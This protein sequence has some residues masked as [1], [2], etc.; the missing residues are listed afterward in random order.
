MFEVGGGRGPIVRNKANFPRHDHQSRRSGRLCETKPISAQTVMAEG[1]QGHPG[2]RRDASCETK[3]ICLERNGWQIFGR[4]RVMT[5]WNRRRLR[6]N[7]ANSRTDRSGQ[8]SAWPPVPLDG[9]IAQNEPNFGRSLKC[10]VPSVKPAK[11]GVESSKSSYFKLYTSNFRRNADSP[12][13]IVRNEANFRP[14]GRPFG[15]HGPPWARFP[16]LSGRVS[17]KIICPGVEPAPDVSRPSCRYW[18]GGRGR[19]H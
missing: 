14:A 8:G 3:P 13:S 7:K 10:E 11:L 12:E 1:R 5:N 6:R 2:H 16:H 17:H 9:P 15:Y 18:D 4:K 19:G